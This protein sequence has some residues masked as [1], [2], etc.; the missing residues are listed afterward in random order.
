[1]SGCTT[2]SCRSKARRCRRASAI[3]SPSTS[4]CARQVRRP[5]MAGRSAAPRDAAHTLPSA[6]R[7]DGQG[8]GGGGGDADRMVRR[9]AADVEPRTAKSPTAVLSALWTTISTRRRPS[10]NCIGCIRGAGRRFDRRTRRRS[11]SLRLGANLLG[12]P[13]N[14]IRD[15]GRSREARACELNVIGER[16][17]S[18]APPQTELG[19]IRPAPRRTRSARRRA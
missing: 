15:A 4:C 13:R 5:H 1:M 16:R 11:A 7:L 12:L 19:R 3:S 9:G 2:A 18:A 17:R 6:D 8:A 14:Q 10:P